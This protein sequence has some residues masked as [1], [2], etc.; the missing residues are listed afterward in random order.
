MSVGLN[1][2]LE[3]S[4]FLDFEQLSVPLYLDLLPLLSFDLQLLHQ[5][6]LLLLHVGTLLLKL[7]NPLVRDLV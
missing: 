6:D 5:F 3:S 1:C 7:R 2:L 4:H